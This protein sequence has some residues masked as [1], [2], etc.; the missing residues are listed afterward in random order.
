V[1]RS[2]QL[3]Y[4]QKP[5]NHVYAID[6]EI[7]VCTEAGQYDRARALV[8][9]LAEKSDRYGLD[10]LYWQLLGA[11]EKAMVDGQRRSLRTIPT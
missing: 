1:H 3:G 7:W 6:M 5:Y 10:Y 2:D 8:G 11:T 9:E 4:P